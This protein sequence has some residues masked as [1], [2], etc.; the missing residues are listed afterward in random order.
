MILHKDISESA[1]SSL[2][3]LYNPCN[4]QDNTINHEKGS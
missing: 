4:I 3:E 1:A 2:M